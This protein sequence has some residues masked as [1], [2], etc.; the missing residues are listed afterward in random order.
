VI[1][2]DYIMRQIEMLGA[3]VR[4]LLKQIDDG[5][6]EQAASDA[7]AASRQFV[8][9]PLAVLE[10][11]PPDGLEAVLSMGEQFDYMRALSAATLLEMRGTLAD[12]EGDETTAFRLW[13]NAANLLIRCHQ[14]PDDQVKSACRSRLDNVLTSLQ[15]YEIPTFLHRN[16]TEFYESTGN[17]SSAEDHLF[18]AITAQETEASAAAW[19][20]GFYD[21]L[22]SL[23]D[24][25]LAAG[26]FSRTEIMESLKELK[27]LLPQP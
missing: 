3:F 14:S 6:L 5:D 7:D 16:L 13:T 24:A 21:R 20:N 10:N 1:R 26:N 8:G 18:Q 4:K 11:Q 17:F 22:Q 9:I 12:S 19:A 15:K 25:Q 2:N 27:Q 23:T